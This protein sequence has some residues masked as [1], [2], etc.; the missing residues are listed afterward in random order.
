M[1]KTNQ[2]RGF[3][4]FDALFS[5]IPV[6]LII[7]F[8]FQISSL[9]TNEAKSSAKSNQLLDKLLSVADYT[10]KIGAVNEEQSVR[11]PNWIEE[12]K[13]TRNYIEDLRNR[14]ALDALYI[15][16]SEPENQ[17]T[18]CIYRLVIFGQTKTIS[19]LFI[20]GT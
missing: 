3:L 11:Y 17:Y 5:V 16:L 1:I 10:I 9:L 13:I 8:T 12:S 20:C 14:S 15:G 2:F 4:S 7:F 19:K 18:I 6:L